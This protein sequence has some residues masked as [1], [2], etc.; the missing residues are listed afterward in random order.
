MFPYITCFCGKSIGDLYDVFHMMRMEEYR[1][2]LDGLDYDLNPVLIST[3]GL[4]VDLS[5]IL[6]N[7]GLTSEC[8]RVRMFTQVIFSDL[9]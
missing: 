7:L 3:I 9:Y 4:H 8:C 5:E 6:T 1:K 2:A